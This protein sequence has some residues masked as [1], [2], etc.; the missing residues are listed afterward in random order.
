VTPR[1]RVTLRPRFGVQM[2]LEPS[3]LSPV[4]VA[5]LIDAPAVEA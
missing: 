1:P 3:A 5:R 4:G 2:V